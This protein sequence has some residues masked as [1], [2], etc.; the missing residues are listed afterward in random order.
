VTVRQLS[1]AAIAVAA[2]VPPAWLE[3]SPTICLFRRITGRPCPSCGLTRS[4]SATAHGRLRNALAHHPFGPLTFLAAVAIA[5]HGS[6][7]LDRPELRDP[8]V[9]TVLGSLWLVTWLGRLLRADQR[10][11]SVL[12]IRMP[13]AQ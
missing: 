1:V 11:A 6:R 9:A 10:P 4:W 13:S 7:A 2:I 12:P 5:L 3:D 8:R